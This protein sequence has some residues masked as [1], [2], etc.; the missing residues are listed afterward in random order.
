VG[1]MVGWHWGNQGGPE[2]REASFTPAPLTIC[3]KYIYIYN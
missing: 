2:W 1:E 3:F